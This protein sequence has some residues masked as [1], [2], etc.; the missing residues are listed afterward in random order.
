MGSPIFFADPPESKCNSNPG[1]IR[2]QLK[3][4]PLIVSTCNPW[5]PVYQ[6]D[7]TEHMW[8]SIVPRAHRL[9]HRFLAGGSNEG[10]WILPIVV[11]R[12]KRKAHR[13]GQTILLLAETP[14]NLNLM[15]LLKYKLHPSGLVPFCWCWKFLQ[16]R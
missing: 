16:R 6:P 7:H 5:T 14:V 9:C 13:K 2:H 10:Y 3:P 11:P 8:S 12:V 15:R 4:E 1:F